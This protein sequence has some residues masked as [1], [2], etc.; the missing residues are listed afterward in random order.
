MWNARKHLSILAALTLVVGVSATTTPA[1][2]DDG[3]W[4]QVGVEYTT[5]LYFGGFDADIAAQ[6]GYELRVDSEGCNT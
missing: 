3:D 6:N 2:A 4:L 1:V 5:P